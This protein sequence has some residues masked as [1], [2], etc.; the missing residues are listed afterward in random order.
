MGGYSL[1]EVAA[2][3]GAPACVAGEQALRSRAREYLS[4][5][6]NR[7]PASGSRVCFA[8]KALPRLAW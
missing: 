3:F 2:R 7:H 8:V 6:A 5:M 1:T 4:A